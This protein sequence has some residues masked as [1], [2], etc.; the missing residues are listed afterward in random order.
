MQHIR[1][2]IVFAH[3]RSGSSSLYQ[4]LQLHPVLNILEE[5]FNENFTEWNPNNP[6]YLACI[7]DIPSLDAQ[8]AEIFSIYNDI[9]FLNYQLPERLTT[10]LLL[11][12]DCFVIFLWRRNLQPLDSQQ[13]QYYL[14]PESVKI[15]SDATYALLSNAQEI[16]RRCGTDETGWLLT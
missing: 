15:N 1:R 13:V 7:H 4:I 16:Q 14:Q 10:H 9:K 11:R 2:V 8:L 6:S 5:P 3:A 12:P